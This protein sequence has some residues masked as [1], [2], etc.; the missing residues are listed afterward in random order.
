MLENYKT[1]YYFDPR[2][3][4]FS[5]LYSRTTTYLLQKLGTGTSPDWP[6]WSWRREP[7][8]ADWRMYQSPLESRQTA[9]SA[10]PSPS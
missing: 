2:K 4:N 7:E 5:S 3:N 8:E 1:S 9:M 10:L 6:Q